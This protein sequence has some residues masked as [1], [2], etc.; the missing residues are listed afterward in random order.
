M[1]TYYPNLDYKYFVTYFTQYGCFG[2]WYSSKNV[3]DVLPELGSEAGIMTTD[4]V[5]L[6]CT[7]VESNGLRVSLKPHVVPR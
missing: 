2:H 6:K 3:P 5:L 7:V 4:G 1:K